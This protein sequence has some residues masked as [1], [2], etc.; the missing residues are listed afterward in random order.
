VTVPE[1]AGKI[2]TSAIEAM[3][4]NPACLAA[5]LVLTMV[6]IL[7]YFEAERRDDRAMRRETDV[8]TLL[9]R[10]YPDENPGARP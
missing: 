8:M 3:R 2:A 1:Q 5:L 10:C 7:Q 6:S 9:N 4:G